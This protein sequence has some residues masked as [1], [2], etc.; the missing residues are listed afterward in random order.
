MSNKNNSS[1]STS[2]KSILAIINSHKF[3][4][5][6]SILR[7]IFLSV[8][9]INGQF[10]HKMRAWRWK[11]RERDTWR[12]QVSER[13]NFPSIFLHAWPCIPF[14]MLFHLLMSRTQHDTAER[15]KKETSNSK[16]IYRYE[17]VLFVSLNQIARSAFCLSTEPD[18]PV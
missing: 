6:H 5:S 14:T 16:L 13:S 11:V 18:I 9:I 7:R 8:N 17:N 4:L 12:K 3:T 2:K 1:S 10:H 15:K